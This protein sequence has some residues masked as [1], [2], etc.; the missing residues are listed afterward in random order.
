MVQPINNSN[1]EFFEGV[2]FL[3]KSDWI[4]RLSGTGQTKVA[5]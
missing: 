1:D 3:H 4:I 5:E 2:G